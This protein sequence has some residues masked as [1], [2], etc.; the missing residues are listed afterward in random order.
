MLSLVE[1]ATYA[2]DD[3]DS[4]LVVLDQSRMPAFDM[5]ADR[6]TIL[7]AMCGA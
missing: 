7:S 3:I 5:G 6:G 4:G 1:E 2:P